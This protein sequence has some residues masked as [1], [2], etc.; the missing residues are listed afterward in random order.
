MAYLEPS[1]EKFWKNHQ[2]EVISR[3]FGSNAIL[4]GDGRCDSPG[5]STKY[6]TYSLMDT[7]TTL[8]RYRHLNMQDR[9]KKCVV[10]FTSSAHFR[11]A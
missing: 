7:S 2:E 5:F 8:V 10:C 6:C 3:V 9:L 4:A 1:I 11:S